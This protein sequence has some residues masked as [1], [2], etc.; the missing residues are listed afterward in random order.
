VSGLKSAN[1][2]D[3]VAEPVGTQEP[4]GQKAACLPET[5]ADPAI[6]DV[7]STCSSTTQ[8]GN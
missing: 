6:S 2:I 8:S 5:P 1:V 7:T 3:V 4:A